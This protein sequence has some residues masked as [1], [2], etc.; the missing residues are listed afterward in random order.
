MGTRFANRSGST[1]PLAKT[2]LSHNSYLRYGFK[3]S[4]AGVFGLS[5]RYLMNRIEGRGSST[6]ESAI[7]APP[8][9]GARLDLGSRTTVVDSSAGSDSGLGERLGGGK[10]QQSF[11]RRLMLKMFGYLFWREEQWW[12][13][14]EIVLRTMASWRFLE[15]PWYAPSLARGI[16]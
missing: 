3:R 15:A 6:S 10:A 13:A 14:M 16:A 8:V 4:L 11:L 1:A 9:A 2:P 12:P 5:A 7:G